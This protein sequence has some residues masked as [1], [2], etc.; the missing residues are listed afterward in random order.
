[1]DIR[2]IKLHPRLHASRRYFI[3]PDGPRLAVAG[4]VT[5]ATNVVNAFADRKEDA[6]NQPSRVFWID[7]IGLPGTVTSLLVLYG[8]AVAASVL[9]GPLFMLVLAVG[10][11]NSI[12]Y[13]VRPLRFKARPLASLVSFS[14][15]VGLSFLSGVAVMGSV[16]LLNP[17]F[18]LLTYF[19][20][21]YGTVKNLPDYSG[22]RKAGT[23]TSATIFHSLANA[24]R[25]SGILLFTPYILL[26]VFV[27]AGSLA[28]IYL[29]DLGM[30]LIF[31]V[32]FFQMLKAKSSQELEKTHTFGFF[33]AISFILFTLV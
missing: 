4:L 1:M 22:D 17:V 18:L 33:Y 19:M 2:R 13:S 25:F 28:P 14:G 9:L 11:F 21:T 30:G 27:A 16:N 8:M 12:F 3:I 24:V 10:I 23:R 26:A 15:A 7:Q 5:A 6:V 29:A 20:F 32:I 31:A